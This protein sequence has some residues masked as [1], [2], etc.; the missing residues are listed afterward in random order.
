M[1]ATHAD[2]H[3]RL[4]SYAQQLGLMSPMVLH[5]LSQLVASIIGS[6]VW[7]LWF[8]GTFFQESPGLDLIPGTAWDNVGLFGLLIGGGIWV[9]KYFRD[10]AMKIEQ[11]QIKSYKDTIR[12]LEREN[13]TLRSL[14]QDDGDSSGARPA[15]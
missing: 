1:D 8:I 7:C 10:R 6:V 12:A 13:A 2:P 4:E 15:V 11:E 5:S 9:V 14:I 3:A